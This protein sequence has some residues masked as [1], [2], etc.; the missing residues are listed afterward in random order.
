MIREDAAA[1]GGSSAKHHQQ[2]RQPGRHR[3]RNFDLCDD[4]KVRPYSKTAPLIVNPVNVELI[5]LGGN[6][7]GLRLPRGVPDNYW[8]MENELGSN[9]REYANDFLRVVWQGGFFLDVG[10]TRR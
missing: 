2:I 8:W 1:Q 6:R 5:S 10:N 9:G 7:W 4:R 3:I